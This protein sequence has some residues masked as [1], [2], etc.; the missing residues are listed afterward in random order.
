M[1]QV[2]KRAQPHI[3]QFTI[4]VIVIWS[5]LFS[6]QLGTSE[7]AFM[8]QNVQVRVKKKS[9]KRSDPLA[10]CIILFFFP[11]G[12]RPPFT[13]SFPKRKVRGTCSWHASLGSPHKT[14]ACAKR[15]FWEKAALPDIAVIM[16]RKDDNILM[17]SGATGAPA[18]GPQGQQLLASLSRVCV[19]GCG[20]KRRSWWPAPSEEVCGSS[21]RSCLG[22]HEESGVMLFHN[23]AFKKSPTQN[24]RGASLGKSCSRS[25]GWNT[26]HFWVEANV[27]AFA[28]WCVLLYSIQRRSRGREKCNLPG[29]NKFDKMLTQQ[30]RKIAKRGKSRSKNDRDAKYADHKKWAH[31]SRSTRGCVGGWAPLNMGAVP[32][33]KITKRSKSDKVGID[34]TQGRGSCIDDPNSPLWEGTLRA[35]RSQNDMIANE[36]PMKGM[37]PASITQFKWYDCRR[38][39]FWGF[40]YFALDYGSRQGL[41]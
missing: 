22:A 19:H 9:Y 17:T 2:C 24:P 13:R 38:K 33:E 27:F 26:C 15:K 4:T 31:C 11:V 6:V 1:K 36:K 21:E 34:S 8:L 41:V 40:W 39:T 5:L 18:H 30:D 28:E 29:E 16:C 14:R 20:L 7:R 37:K 32:A 3:D 35:S 10:P 25:T 12:P 23:P